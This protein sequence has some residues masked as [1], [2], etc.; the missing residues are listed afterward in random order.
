MDTQ[1]PELA[2][3]IADHQAGRLGEAESRYRQ[4]LAHN[5]H[6]ID[7]LHLLGVLAGQQGRLQV[8]V[9]L[10]S[11]AAARSGR[12]PLIL[13]N[14]ANVLRNQGRLDTAIEHYREAIRL[15]PN[16]ALAHLNLGETLC[17]R[18]QYREAI[19]CFERAL[20][21]NSTRGNAHFQLGLALAHLG[22]LEPARLHYE[23]ALALDPANFAAGNN[24]GTVCQDLGDRLAAR[25]A[26]ELAIV[27][28][29]TCM[30]AHFNLG[31]LCNKQEQYDAAE[32]HFRRVLALR[33]DFEGAYAALAETL[34][35][36]GR[37]GEAHEQLTRAAA[38]QPQKLVWQLRPTILCPAVFA[39]NDAI[40]EYR[41]AVAAKLNALSSPSG[42]HLVVD[43]H[44]LGD[45]SCHPPVGWA[46]QGRN[47]LPLK[48]QFADL[49]AGRLRDDSVML[50]H[51]GPKHRRTSAGPLHVG[52]VVTAG[53]EGV[54]LRGM[55]GVL[56]RL[57]PR[58]FQVTV[59]CPPAT[60][61]R[62]R[63]EIRQPNVEYLPLAKSLPGAIEALRAARFNLLYYWEIGTDAM[64]YFLP[65]FRLASVQCASWGWPISSG[66]PTVDYFIS[67]KL[68]EPADGASHYR[69]TLVC[70][71]HL[72]NYYECPPEPVASDRAAFGWSTNQHVYF[73]GQSPRK[74]QPDMDQL[75]ADLLRADPE[76]VVV[77]ISATLEHV[78]RSLE[79]R[80]AQHCPDVAARIQFVPRL[81]AGEYRSL[82]AAAD[83]VLDTL[84]YAGG[85]NSTYDTLAAAT[86][87]VTL[88]GP[89]HRGRYT[90]TVC[91]LLGL[92]ECI[93]ESP[94]DYV[95]KAVRLASDRKLH[96]AVRRKIRERRHMLFGNVAAVEEL[97]SF[98]ET[99]VERA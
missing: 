81:S 22:Q 29:P 43:L 89:Y 60:V 19:P 28:S 47:D 5:P 75:I 59:V 1:T 69:E 52:F 7:A 77:L 70:L 6:D 23:R 45:S 17:Q 35:F 30:E 3:A 40:D 50:P 85:A 58:R 57:D 61:A 31:A 41:G 4:M 79:A 62:C 95:Q 16:F 36:Q 9:D 10:I 98:F 76:G 88:P 24:L 93:A 12:H 91:G 74:I 87:L 56:A 44:E 32:Q 46:Y 49:F 8:A 64:N 42:Q 54:F 38:L 67:S 90:A 15:D 51:D 68:L 92:E 66:I 73:C 34:Q 26:Y 14:L 53:N 25:R 63:Q 33:P 48:S 65:F 82:S 86:P 83:V 96:D 84:H 80:F 13:G 20:E 97:A 11:Q 37:T 72:P 78:T 55:A 18:Q 39:D 21:I 27:A 94:A 2:A 71:E 99:A